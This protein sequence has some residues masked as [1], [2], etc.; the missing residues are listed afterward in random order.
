VNEVEKL[1]GLDF[2]RALPAAEQTRL[3]RTNR[4]LPAH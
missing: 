4:E 2:F 1:T 3:E